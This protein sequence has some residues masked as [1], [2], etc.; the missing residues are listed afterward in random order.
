MD[1]FAAPKAVI[2]RG[3]ETDSLDYHVLGNA[4]Q[5]IKGIQGSVCE[6]GTRRGG[7]MKV[8]VDALLDNADFGR[9]VLCVDP[10]GNI[11]YAGGENRAIRYDYTND[12][13]NESYAAIYQYAQGRPVNIVVLNLEDTEFFNR[14]SD[15]YPFYN[16]YK[17]ISNTY[18]LVFFDGPHDTPSLYK[19][20]EFFYPR[21]PIG[22]MWV[23]DDLALYPH[24]NIDERL[25]DWG[26]DMIEATER[27]ASYRRIR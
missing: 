8:I 1:D 18:A 21:C 7:S 23:F 2:A 14:F 6:L 4:A 27:K 13:R 26:F 5:A 12:M 15:G 20:I 25:Y 24:Q 22:G 17:R 3:L 16:Q 11:E 10:Y 9:D 19:E